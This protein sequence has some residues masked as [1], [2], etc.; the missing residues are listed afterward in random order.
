MNQQEWTILAMALSSIGGFGAFLG[1]RIGQQLLTGYSREGWQHP[2]AHGGGLLPFT[3]AGDDPSGF[4]PGVMALVGDQA[5]LTT[6]AY[7]AG[8]RLTPHESLYAHT[9]IVREHHRRLTAFLSLPDLPP[10]TVLQFRQAVHP[11]SRT[12]VH[13]SVL[14]GRLA[15]TGGKF[16]FWQRRHLAEHEALPNYVS[17]TFTLFVAIGQNAHRKSTWKHLLEDL[18]ELGRR[19]RKGEG[20]A[21]LSRLFAGST[22]LQ[23]F[24]EEERTVYEEACNLFQT[25]EMMLPFAGRRMKQQEL[26]EC[27]YFGH[28]EDAEVAPRT[29][30]L[31]NDVWRLL[32]SEPVVFAS[33]AVIQGHTPLGIVS[34][35]NPPQFAAGGQVGAY[36]TLLRPLYTSPSLD[37]RHTIVTEYITLDQLKQRARYDRMITYNEKFAVQILRGGVTPEGRQKLIELQN[38]RADMASGRTTVLAGRQRVVVFGP[39]LSPAQLEAVTRSLS[40]QK[41][42]PEVWEQLESRLKAVVAA[43]RQ[44]DGVQSIIESPAGRRAQYRSLLPGEVSDRLTGREFEEIAPSLACFVGGEQAWRM[45]PNPHTVLRSATGEYVGLDIFDHQG[46]PPTIGIFGR[47][48]SGKSVL[49]GMLVLEALARY[50][51]ARAQIVD[52]NSFSRLGMATGGQVFRFSPEDRR[53]FNVWYYDGLAEGQKPEEEQ[54]DLVLGDIKRLAGCELSNRDV[55]RVFE[56]IVRELYQAVCAT[57][58]ALVAA[59]EA[60]PHGAGPGQGAVRWQE[61]TLSMFLEF[62]EDALRGE[63]F[64]PL[65]DVAYTLFTSLQRH[66]GNPW[67]DAPMDPAYLTDSRLIIYDLDSLSSFTVDMRRAL[68]YRVAVRVTRALTTR[69]G[70]RLPRVNFFDEFKRLAD[71]YPEVLYV[72]ERGTR[73]GR[74]ENV[75]TIFA[76]QTYD[77]IARMPGIAANLGLKILGRQGGNQQSLINDFKLP[78]AAV[79]AVE[80]IENI[81][82]CYAQF[83][84]SAGEAMTHQAELV[85]SEMSPTYNWMFTTDPNECTAFNEVFETLGSCEAAIDFLAWRYPLG[86]HQSHLKRLTPQDREALQ[87]YLARLRELSRGTA[88]AAPGLSHPLPAAGAPAVSIGA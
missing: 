38:L 81:P 69:G 23:R 10:G 78:A 85:V 86:F 28:N 68:S 77:D 27:I 1:Y 6:G 62:V 5:R 8:F 71:D 2:G 43:Y 61:P 83:L 32:M 51:D 17:R 57:N 84:I 55:D 12:D 35:T 42:A 50:P 82:G 9:D 21:Y 72:I 22:F 67:L 80:S 44:I 24:V 49:G 76:T 14:G 3:P 66:I 60:A 37:F 7:L 41:D 33:E 70:R 16:D 59:Q 29:P 88:F 45:S 52:F 46:R 19:A 40:L 47:S 25:L 75:T 30:T 64:G 15:G 48:G 54:I 56:V 39:R 31:E 36:P 74:K 53:G 11:L 18:R 58:R 34:M 65:Q 79:S 73:Q 20:M 4:E 26:W 87:D 63:R 13:R